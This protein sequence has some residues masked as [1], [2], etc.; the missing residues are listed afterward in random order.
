MKFSP[1]GSIRLEIVLL[2]FS[3]V[4][5]NIAMFS[6]G[7]LGD[8][9]VSFYKSVHYLVRGDNIYTSSYPHPYNG[10]DYPPFNP[11]WAIYTIVP[12]SLFP[13]SIA[14]PIRYFL[15]LVMIP[16]VVYLCARMVNLNTRWL[17]L[18]VVTAPWHFI[19]LYAGQWTSLVFLGMLACYYGV[20]QHNVPLVVIGMWLALIKVNLTLL[21]LL[22]TLGF[23]WRKGMFS[24]IAAGLTGLVLVSSLAQPTW[25][26]DLGM[27][28]LARLQQ[29]RLE[30]S[31][32]LLPGYPWAQLVFLMLGALWVGWYSFRA[33]VSQPESWFWALLIVIGLVSALH[34]FTYD[35][36]VLSLPMMWLLRHNLK[37]L[38]FVMIL[39]VYPLIW[40]TVLAVLGLP[41]HTAFFTLAAFMM[42]PVWGVLATV[43][44][45]L[46]YGRQTMIIYFALI[47]MLG[48][49]TA[50]LRLSPAFIPC[51][52]LMA[53]VI[54]LWRQNI[55]NAR[56]YEGMGL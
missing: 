31:V 37:N 7:T 1:A 39:Y 25:F 42:L 23:A 17:I 51:A 26:Y 48:A 28:Y 27:L 8:Y 2:F 11:I 9:Q 6:T 55:R 19:T 40:M 4:I 24:R 22:A 49:L 29:P 50:W 30:D 3:L 41:I 13:F 38:G 43:L 45:G 20:R 35:W 34:T 12:I 14:G 56:L 54:T 47:V 32:L 18:V 44:V 16:F 10:R 5:A 36:I 33:R 46:V 15:D 21:V 53:M 52:V